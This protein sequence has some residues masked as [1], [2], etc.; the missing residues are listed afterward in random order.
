VKRESSSSANADGVSVRCY[1]E[2]FENWWRRYPKRVGKDAA[3]KAYRAARKRGA[4]ADELIVGIER[5][6]WSPDQQY[7]PHPSTWLNGGRWKDE[8]PPLS[9]SPLVQPVRVRL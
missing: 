2:E 1:D 3:A 6:P 7:I 8:P 5:Y 4:S 9:R